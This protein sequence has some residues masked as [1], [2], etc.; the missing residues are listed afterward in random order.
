VVAAAQ[1]ERLPACALPEAAEFADVMAESQ[2]GAG[3]RVEVWNG[4][5]AAS[6][7]F[8]QAV[9]IRADSAA[10]LDEPVQVFPARDEFQLSAPGVRILP[11]AEQIRDRSAATAFAVAAAALRTVDVPDEEQESTAAAKEGSKAALCPWAAGRVF[12]SAVSIRVGSP[13]QGDRVG[14]MAAEL[15]WGVPGV[16]VQV[17]SV[18]LRSGAPD[19]VVA[20]AERA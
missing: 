15:L 4:R 10:A 16:A 19:D 6:R 2:A 14:Q 8:P 9:L 7:V 20:R 13:A 18:K 5:L 17:A 12:P 1:A 3:L 11:E